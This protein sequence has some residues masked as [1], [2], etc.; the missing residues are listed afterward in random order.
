VI[1]SPL[2][3]GAV[4][5]A[6]AGASILA[7]AEGIRTGNAKLDRHR[8]TIAKHVLLQFNL[9]A[10]DLRLAR[11][12]MAIL[13]NESA[14]LPA[15]VVGD[16][17]NSKGPSVGPMQVSRATA[18]DLGL[19]TPPPGVTEEQARNLF[20]LNANDEG[21][22]I[23]WGVRIFADKLRIAGDDFPLAIRLYNGSGPSAEAYRAKALDFYAAKWG[24]LPSGEITA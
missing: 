13:N 4:V 8:Q 20:I 18:V 11:A 15:P 16:K 5:M 21:K 7:I 24:P 17:T 22:C 1:G 23:A 14:G 12:C 6:A 10:R 9:R 2:V 3:L 19:W